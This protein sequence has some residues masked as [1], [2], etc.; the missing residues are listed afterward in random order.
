MNLSGLDAA[1]LQHSPDAI[2]IVDENGVIELANPRTSEM[3]GYA[4]EDLVGQSVELLVPEDLATAHKAHRTRYR[5]EPHTRPMGE[6]G[7]DLYGRRA[8][9]TVFPVE[10]SLSPLGQE[11]PPRVMACVRDVSERHLLEA[12][13]RRVRDALDAVNEAVFMFEPKT[14]RFMYVNDGAVEQVGY[15]RAEL[16]GGMTPLHVKPEFTKRSFQIL[17]GRLTSGERDTLTFTT[18]HRRKDGTDLD[19][20]VALQYLETRQGLEGVMV[21]MARDITAR[22][23][24]ERRARAD[25]EALRVAEERERIARDLH[26][27]VIQRLFATGMRLQAGLTDPDLIGERSDETIGE[28]DEIIAVIRRTIFALTDHVAVTPSK[29]IQA[30][31]DAHTDRTGV[32]VDVE[33]EGDVDGVAESVMA[34][35]EAS[36][37]EALSNVVRHAAA[38]TVSVSVAVGDDVV[39]RVSDDGVGLPDDRATG[40]GLPN[41]GARA[42]E[43]GGRFSIVSGPEGG[44][45]LEWTVPTEQPAVGGT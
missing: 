34:G 21:A 12:E 36:L 25:R 32:C 20:E 24:A 6:P 23:A 3:F 41:M 19:V 4:S 14:L 30:L 40:F 31:A 17:I 44:T 35:L 37:T 10:I 27:V 42:E 9:G 29:R 39:M 28:L 8:D 15:D 1:Y 11:G 22:H 43:L 2:V 45:D 16:L 5:V 13:A 38:Q 7:A 33:L 18:T 26:D